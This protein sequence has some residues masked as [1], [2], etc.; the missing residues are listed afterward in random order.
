MT[1]DSGLEKALT[2]TV[3]SD[4]LRLVQVLD[5][6]VSRL[7]R[8]RYG[9]MPLTQFDK[10]NRRQQYE[11][12]RL[13]V[14]EILYRAHFSAATALVRSQRWV[15]GIAAAKGALNLLSFAA[16]FR[17]LIESSADALDAL[18]PATLGIAKGWSHIRAALDSTRNRTFVE[19]GAIEDALIAFMYA[20]RL[21]PKERSSA[22]ASHAAKSSADYLALLERDSVPRIRDCYA[23]LCQLT[24]PAADS[25][26]S[27]ARF[28]SS[29]DLLEL[30]PSADEQRIEEFCAEFS[31][32]GADVIM[33]GL[34]P[35]LVMLKLL[36]VFHIE[37]VYTNAV[38]SINVNVIPLWAR[39][40][41]YLD[42]QGWHQ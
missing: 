7:R 16:S 38:D 31:P 37:S 10:L 15:Y 41:E 18:R 20:R 4:G 26:L 3:G 28:H 32:T 9:F 42:A 21:T 19:F 29:G 25:V 12:R 1:G 13:Y 35:G 17:G 40:H 11:G 23:L 39:V 30:W 36:N 34:N 2:A 33:L 8:H 14:T 5:H 27:Y 22:P 6:V 24:H